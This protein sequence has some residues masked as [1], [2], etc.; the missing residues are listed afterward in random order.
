MSMLSGDASVVPLETY[1]AALDAEVFVVFGASF[2]KGA[3]GR[4][5]EEHRAS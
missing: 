2:L 1:G 5:L 4:F 3:L